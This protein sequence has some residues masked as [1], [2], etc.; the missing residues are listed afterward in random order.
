MDSKVGLNHSKIVPEKK[1][2][3]KKIEIAQK[4]LNVYGKWPLNAVY[5]LCVVWFTS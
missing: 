5:A 2:S 1:D 3:K 4:L